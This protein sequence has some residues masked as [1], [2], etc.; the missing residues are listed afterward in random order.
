MMDN[1]DQFKLV[2][3]FKYDVMKNLQPT[4]NH[5]T[6]SLD[7]ISDLRLGAL[8][9]IIE[10]E[11]EFKY[12][13][14]MI[15]VYSSRFDRTIM[16]HFPELKYTEDDIVNFIKDPK[17][18]EVLIKTSPCTELEQNLPYL[19]ST[20]V[21]GNRTKPNSDDSLSIRFNSRYF[22]VPKHIQES[23]TN[24]LSKYVNGGS[25]SFRSGPLE[26]MEIGEI[27]QTDAIVIY[28]LN[29]FFNSANI[30]ELILEKGALLTKIIYGIFESVADIEDEDSDEFK[31][32]VSATEAA[33][34]LVCQFKFVDNKLLF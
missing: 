21:D 9:A 23:T 33:L 24:R 10:E 6:I 30:S 16:N 12:I 34:N 18:S 27:L 2:D 11:W 5:M 32:M 14:S 31:T 8:L 15:D 3:Q 28:Y 26:D 20:I 17:N 13:K 29:N 25:I 19:L 1:I 7:A 4:I 22:E